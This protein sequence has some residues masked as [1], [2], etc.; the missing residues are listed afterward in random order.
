MWE[1]IPAI[2]TDNRERLGYPTQK[3]ESLLERIIRASSNEGDTILDPFCGCGTTITVAQRLKR[4][5][6][7]IDVT[8]LAINLIKHRLV[9]F[10]DK[11]PYKVI[12]EPVSLSEAEVLAREDP[13]Q[14]QFWALGLVGA[15]PADE[16]KGADKGIDGQLFFH[17]DPNNG[18]KQIIFSVKAGK[19]SVPHVRDLRGVM[20]REDA[21]IG[22]LLTMQEPTKPMIS[23]AAGA[24]FYKSAWGKHPRLQI[25]TIE[26]L[27][28]GKRV[29]YPPARQVNQTF[30]KAPKA[31]GSGTRLQ[32]IL[33]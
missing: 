4:R 1:D 33:F 11:A 9:S 20:E 25:L 30:K 22:V 3:P 29:D 15:R 19:T 26:E 12:G 7:G 18:T 24:G 21:Q 16:K 13:Y 2:G 14:F 28:N 8:Y 10:E 32:S 6:I 5:W 31:K 23:E 27:L 17:D